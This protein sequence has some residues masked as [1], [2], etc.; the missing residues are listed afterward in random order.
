MNE[1]GALKIAGKGRMAPSET[2]I[3]NNLSL[4]AT[5]RRNVPKL[6]AQQSSIHSPWFRARIG[7][8]STSFFCFQV[9]CTCV[10]DPFYH[11]FKDGRRDS[12]I[13]K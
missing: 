8:K 1:F 10:L 5:M 6:C 12:T 2:Y 4:Q 9:E 3:R 11:G 7:K 13:S